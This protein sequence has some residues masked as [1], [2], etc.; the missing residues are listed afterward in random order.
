MVVGNGF[1]LC[2]AYVARVNSGFDYITGGVSKE[3][4]GLWRVF[5]YAEKRKIFSSDRKEIIRKI[6]EELPMK[7][8]SVPTTD[9]TPFMHSGEYPLECD[10]EYSFGLS[11][12]DRLEI[13]VR[14]REDR[15]KEDLEV[16]SFKFGILNLG[17]LLF[18]LIW[19]Y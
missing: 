4:S 18:F 11:G 13:V 15:N 8:S 12:F 10:K 19:F 5:S 3:S 7:L 9:I 6:S 17:N 16:L 2:N 1:D 14:N